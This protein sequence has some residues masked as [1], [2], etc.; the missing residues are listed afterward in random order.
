MHNEREV[1]DI[2]KIKY[3]EAFQDK[4]IENLD[5]FI[6]LIC[7]SDFTVKKG[8]K[9]SWDFIKKDNNSLNRF[10][11]FNIFLDDYLGGDS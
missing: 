11:N 3:S 10:T 1:E 6:D 9:E 4:Y 2:L 8:Y 7:K 5:D